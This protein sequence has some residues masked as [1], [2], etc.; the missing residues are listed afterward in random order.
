MKAGVKWGIGGF[1]ALMM[2]GAALL[3]GWAM[4]EIP[5]SHCIEHALSAAD[6][7]R[8][9]KNEAPLFLL[10][11]KE[12]T[13]AVRYELTVKDATGRTVFEQPYA[14]Q[15]EYILPPSL[16]PGSVPQGL[17][18]QVRALDLDGEPISTWS[19]P[20]LL[21]DDAAL[22]TIHAPV[23]RSQY[24]KG[25]GTDLLYPVY[26]YTAYPGAT[27]YEVE[28][29]SREPE[30]SAQR[31]AS[32]YRI[33]R[34]ESELTDIYD[35]VPRTGSYY[36]RVRALDAS[37]KPMTI[38]SPAQ[39][40]ELTDEFAIGVY[41]DSIS[42]GGGRLSYGPT[43]WAYSYESYLAEP[44]VN[45]SESGDTS[46]RMAERFASDVKPFSHLKTLLILGGTN[47]LRAS[48]SADDVIE[49]LKSIQAQARA[50][51]IRPV[52]MT[53]PP[54]NPAQIAK[55][56]DQPT[57]ADWQEKFAK[58]NAF[59]RTQPHI[60]TAAPFTRYDEMPKELAMD[61]LHGDVRAK[62]MM[63]SAINQ[64]LAKEQRRAK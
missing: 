44:V 45:L 56:F 5:F 49:D 62:M 63:A 52:L 7:A 14:F 46:A 32:R 58:V 25:N 64:A 3:A 27:S 13:D 53:L 24:H 38:W 22:L 9:A 50:R 23:P 6:A 10:R 60:D 2:F 37:G 1:A 55:A 28:V 42:H 15:S 11:W 39:H 8:Q 18:Y 34:Y 59:I 54:I 17:T 41:G 12:N 33:A 31:R 35:P 51:G 40:V 57:A 48:T 16:T 30:P 61:G 29:T 43:D 26:A 20:R 47:S 4:D 19:R 21:A 36:W